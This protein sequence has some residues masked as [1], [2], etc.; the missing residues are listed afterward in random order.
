[1]NEDKIIG[2]LGAC[3]VDDVAVVGEEQDLG[4]SRE[5]G[6]LAQGGGGRSSSKFSRMSSTTKGTDSCASSH[7][8]RLASLKAR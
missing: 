4:A 8:S 6:Q 1:M 3:Q 2:K 7:D 5:P